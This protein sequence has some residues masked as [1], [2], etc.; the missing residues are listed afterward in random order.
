Q[1]PSRAASPPLPRLSVSH[2]RG[3]FRIELLTACSVRDGA[4]T[5]IRAHVSYAS[6]P[7]FIRGEGE[8]SDPDYEDKR[9]EIGLSLFD[10]WL[11]SMSH[12][13]FPSG[14]GG[15][16]SRSAIGSPAS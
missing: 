7:S 14:I 15:M 1:H 16:R 13:V 6:S 2:S 11:A 8:I 12:G 10:Q 4:V 5:S 3:P 9:E